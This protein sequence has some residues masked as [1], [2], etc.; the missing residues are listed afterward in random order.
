MSTPPLRREELL[1]AIAEEEARLAKLE[2]DQAAA[3]GR[4]VGLRSELAEYRAERKIDVPLPLVA[5][6]PTPRT[7]DEKVKLFR[8]LFR[9][10]VR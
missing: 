9:G 7:S 2:A 8:S 4:L 6:A 10:R 1:T 3:R 5:D